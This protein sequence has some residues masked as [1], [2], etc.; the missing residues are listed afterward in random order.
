MTMNENPFKEIESQGFTQL[1]QRTLNEDPAQAIANLLA[2][3][4]DGKVLGSV[5]NVLL[6]KKQEGNLAS[7]Q[8]LAKTLAKEAMTNH[9]TKR[10]INLLA[11]DKDAKFSMSDMNSDEALSLV[12]FFWIFGS[13]QISDKDGVT[14]DTLTTGMY[15]VWSRL[16]RLYTPPKREDLESFFKQADKNKD[17]KLNLNEFHDFLTIF[18]RSYRAGLLNNLL[19]RLI[20]NDIW[21]QDLWKDQQQQEYIK[22]AEAAFF[23]FLQYSLHDNTR[24][25]VA[26]E[27]FSYLDSDGT[28]SISKK[29]FETLLE[30]ACDSKS[31]IAKIWKTVDAN[32]DGVLDFK[33]FLKVCETYSVSL[34][35]EF[36]SLLSQETGTASTLTNIWNFLQGGISKQDAAFLSY[37][38][39]QAA[40]VFADRNRNGKLSDDEWQTFATKL[41]SEW[42]KRIDAYVPPQ[43]TEPTEPT[44]PTQP[45]E[46]ETETEETEDTEETEEEPTTETEE[47][48]EESNTETEES[49]DDETEEPVEEHEEQPP[50]NEEEEIETPIEEE[51]EN[52]PVNEEEEEIETPVEEQEEENPPVNEE[53]EI[54]TPV[55]EEEE[56]PPVNEEEEIE[57]PVEEEEENPP[58]NEEEEIET[59]VEEQ[60]EENPPINEEEEIETPVEEQEEENPPVNEE[61][62]IE[63][64][65]EEEEEEPYQEVPE[66]LP[67]PPKREIGDLQTSDFNGDGKSDFIRRPKTV[68]DQANSYIFVSNGDGT[69][70]K[71]LINSNYYIPE[72]T[73]DV[74]IGDFNADG[75]TDIFR[76]EKGAWEN[77]GT[78]NAQILF[79]KGDG[80]FLAINLPES[81]DLKGSSATLSFG[82][83][84]GDGKTDFIRQ[85]NNDANAVTATLYL[86]NGDGTFRSV[87]VG[88]TASPL[89][90]DYTNIVVGDFNGDGLFDFIRQEKGIWAS[91]EDINSATL[92]IAT[93]DGAFR[94]V[95]LPSTMNIKGTEVNLLVGD[96]NGDG[97][98]DFLSQHLLTTT[99]SVP[100]LFISNGADGF[101]TQSLRGKMLSKQQAD[102]YIGNF[103]GDT[104]IDFL[105][106][107]R[108][109]TA[110]P[111]AYLYQSSSATKPYYY[112]TYQLK[113]YSIPADYVNLYIGDFNGDGKSDILRQEEST[114]TGDTLTTA[115]LLLSNAVEKNLK[116]DTQ[117]QGN[118][119]FTI[120]ALP[121]TYDLSGATCNLLVTNL[122]GTAN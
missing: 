62:E 33:E 105:V 8:N 30:K 74:Y 114:F 26:Y 18:L 116:Y 69:F 20:F 34:V 59:P 53:E 63:T 31:Q 78:P 117:V 85:Q 45:T 98:D 56:N 28:G 71:I 29:E 110:N 3:N 22:L 42:K 5:S 1:V 96:F 7:Y 57:T 79:S 24:A 76:R 51:E 94:T 89:P 88:N 91:A 99:T 32:K 75:K 41:I 81:Y 38:D 54:E 77:D 109:P 100:T 73:T 83:F 107:Q 93:G 55:E 14:L 112:Y 40:F 113:T 37:S 68:S 60:E 122:P 66:P 67:V 102:V 95:D 111:Q 106:Q 70:N 9:E 35:G 82:D 12:T 25:Q 118:T 6:S 49:T 23:K 90:A 72:E 97:K 4:I 115:S 27:I 121:D 101:D 92:F 13:N 119:A 10:A 87:S 58:V 21:F 17:G 44:E 47:T 2:Y 15:E 52:P 61:E 103:D 104:R 50:A 46:P 64:P 65:V 43:P 36:G 39:V 86:S 108:L 48:E 11:L 84:N 120:V 19:A 16:S 80:N